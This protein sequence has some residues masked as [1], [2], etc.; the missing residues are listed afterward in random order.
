MSL[1]SQGTTFSFTGFTA[2]YTSISVQE[3]TP[4]IVDITKVTDSPSVRRMVATGAI[5]APAKVQVAYLRTTATPAILN[6]QGL[7]G[8]LTISHPSISSVSK[9]AII[10]SATSE[11]AVGQLMQGTLVFVI[12]NST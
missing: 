8:T 12:D 10:E 4:E 6:A 11:I 2:L 1:S 9:A 3:A 7:S 5:L